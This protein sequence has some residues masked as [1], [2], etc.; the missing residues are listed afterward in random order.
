MKRTM[1]WAGLAAGAV[2]AGLW[3]KKKYAPGVSLAP[4]ISP[5]QVPLVVPGRVAVERVLG[6]T[7]PTAPLPLVLA[8]HGVSADETQLA[9]YVLSDTPVRVVFLRGGLA[10]GR[11]FQWFRARIKGPSAAF[12][13]QLSQ[14]A[15]DVLAALDTI[16]SQRAVSRRIVLGYSQGAHLAWWLATTGR[17][18]HVIAVSGALP[19]GVP[20]PRSGST[21]R[22]EA[23]HGTRDPVVPF[24]AG[25]ATARMFEAAGYPVRFT[26]IT[27]AS[28]ALSG[29]GHTI[30]PALA[31]A[32]RPHGNTAAR[33]FGLRFGTR[34]APR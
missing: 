24:S 30:A 6:T 28:H 33:P 13:A 32:L 27:L 5:S 12:V 3:A 31:A 7:D 15:A 1:V 34:L 22:I 9:P 14:T 25:Q 29:I 17:L 19:P 26:S 2:G 4:A 20:L 11:G 21:T 8:L 10:S 16:A 18:D 23:A